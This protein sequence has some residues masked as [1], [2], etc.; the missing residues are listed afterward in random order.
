MTGT[1]DSRDD[2]ADEVGAAARD[3]QV[4]EAAGG[5]ERADG[6]VAALEEADGV[7]G[8]ALGRQ[9]VPQDATVARLDSARRCPRGG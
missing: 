6:A 5:H 8:E 7:G 1:V 4:D 9:R 3:E 2:R